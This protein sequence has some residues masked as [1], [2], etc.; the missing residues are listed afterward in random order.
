MI[1]LSIGVKVAMAW[2]LS[3]ATLWVLI[4]KHIGPAHK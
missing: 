2:F 1:V 3:S 4:R